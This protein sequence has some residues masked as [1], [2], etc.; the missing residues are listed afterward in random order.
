MKNNRFKLISLAF[1][2]LLSSM[3]SLDAKK[4]G[5]YDKVDSK[6]MSLWVDSVYNS[7]TPRERI[8]QLFM[9]TII[10]QSDVVMN[11]IAQYVLHDKVGG[12]ILSKGSAATFATS[13]N[14]AQQQAT[15]PLLISVDGEWGPAMRVSDAVDYPRNI[16][17]GAISD[18]RLLYEYGARVAR[19]C[20]ALGIYVNFAPVL[21]VLTAESSVLGNRP[22]GSLPENVARKGVAFSRG[23]EDGLVLSVAKHF[24]GH[25][26]TEGD[27]HKM[28]PTVERN[29]AEMNA[30]D[31]LPFTRYIKAGLGGMLNGHLSLPK[32]DPSG[33]PSSLSP[34][35]VTDLLGKKFGFEGLV[36]T[37]ALGMKGALLEGESSAV[38]A[39]VAGNDVLL[40]IKNIQSE[41]AAI[42]AAVAN[43]TIPASRI[44]SSCRKILSYKYILGSHRFAPVDSVAT[45][46]L[47]NDPSAKAL[48]NRLWHASMTL[49]KDVNNVIPLGN[50]AENQI[51][52][53]G[54]FRT[55]EKMLRYAR[56]YADVKAGTIHGAKFFDTVLF[57][58]S[59]NSEYE[60]NTL[61][62]LA[63]TGKNV[64][65]V[66]FC[67]PS[68]VK[69]FASALSKPNVA[70]M[71]AFDDDSSAVL[72]AVEGIFGGC[73]L[74]GKTPVDI[75]G[76]VKA[77][78]GLERK[79]CRLGY[80]MPEEVG[81][82]NRILAQVD[83]LAQLGVDTGAFPGCQ[84]LL[85]KGGK[86]IYDR[87]FGTLDNENATDEFSL[88]D[89]AS[90]SKATGT[91]P[92]IMKAYDDGLIDLE[93]PIS[94][95]IPQLV[96]S[97]KENIKVRELLFHE[98]A[99][100]PSIDVNDAVL[101]HDS[102]SGPLFKKTSSSIYSVLVNGD[103]W[104][105]RKARVRTDLYSTT[106]SDEYPVEI[107][108][109]LYGITAIYD[110]IIDRAYTIKLRPDKKYAYSCV[111]FCLLMN[112]EQNVTHIPHDKY[113]NDNFYARLGAYHTCYCPLRKFSP[114]NIAPTE[115]DNL[116]R[117]QML[118][119]YVH[120]ETAG[121]AGGV[122][123]NAGLFSN[124]DDL[125]KLCQMWLNGGTYGGERL[126][127]EKTVKL[128]TTL[129]SPTCRRGL[130]FDKP[131]YEN[132][133][134]SPTCDEATPSTFGHLGF[135]GTV[136]WVDP[137]ND[138]FMIFLCNRVFPTRANAAFDDLN[139]RPQLFATFY[140][141]LL[142]PCAKPTMPTLATGKIPMAK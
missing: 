11:D 142:N 138:M 54:G 65:A 81:V 112:I 126:L 58:I 86:I 71:L 21:D 88:Y 29:L 72:A 104:A 87:Y 74:S 99:I 76:V 115:Q 60:I 107:A 15:T 98:S 77:G 20:R 36:F 40:G 93:A 5:L 129:K 6:A 113:V 109:G 114:D 130:G 37:D 97:D 51:C 43:G 28:L 27:S 140:R 45:L 84:V 141:N 46:N 95:Y 22:Y 91:L 85:A 80:A 49:F 122:Q 102:Y 116:L 90:V 50:L 100:P 82:N 106:R 12:L 66:F 16:A 105:N 53:V 92:G 121:M 9:P 41:L 118:R 131:N 124:A 52:V 132:P 83:S 32:I 111:N 136:F 33:L 7:L 139:I 110:T 30:C 25:G 35:I 18:D 47:L 89:L 96:G 55:S 4:P 61:N 78:V 75:P 69:S 64:V 137:D 120:D 56:R 1:A 14:A 39:I 119:G 103:T 127:S 70:A 48:S 59:G 62:T 34:A 101:D 73:D 123:G 44:E 134:Y 128:F 79:A 117:H 94:K 19:E 57:P 10:P 63:A 31:L 23:M 67:H 17:L 108:D 135:T 125:A 2:L 38:K 26:S 133:E 68:K 42:E 8:S 13:V 24:P 3:F